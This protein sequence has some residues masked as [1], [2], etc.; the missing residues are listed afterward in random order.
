MPISKD[1]LHEHGSFNKNKFD[2][3]VVEDGGASSVPVQA[4]RLDYISE[5]LGD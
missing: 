3:N 1:K 2:L 5:R 4:P